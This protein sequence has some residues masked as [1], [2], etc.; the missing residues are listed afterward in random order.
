MCS[1]VFQQVLT[2]LNITDVKPRWFEASMRLQYGTLSHLPIEVFEQEARIVQGM[3]AEGGPEEL[4]E[5]AE[6]FGL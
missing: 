5:L 4:D 2:K 6:S 3:L 1:A